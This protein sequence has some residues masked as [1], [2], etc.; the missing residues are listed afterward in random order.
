MRIGINL[1]AF[2]KNK[3]TGLIV[4]GKELLESLGKLKTN[5]EF[6]L[7]FPQSI[8]QDL[9]FPYE[10]FNYITLPL[11][12]HQK[13]KR[14]FFE[15][16]I[17]PFYLKKNKI[18]VLFNLTAFHPLFPLT[19]SVT[20]VH[21]GAPLKFKITSLT[22]LYIRFMYFSALKFSSS[23]ITLSHFAK[24]EILENI[25]IPTEKIKIIYPGPPKQ[26]LVNEEKQKAIL[27]K[28]KIKTPYFFFI[29]TISHNKN[30]KNLIY[31]FK[32]ISKKYPD[33]N[34]VLS[35][36]ISPE[37]S[38]IKEIIKNLNLEKKIIITNSIRTEEKTALFK[39]SIA[40][41]FPSFHEG[42]GFPVLEA[43][44]LGIPVLTSNTSALPEVA[45]EG[46]LFVNPFKIQS[47]A[48]S[49]K[50]ISFNEKLRK[51]LIKKGFENLK[52]FSWEKTAQ[53]T[54]KVLKEA[55]YENS[56]SS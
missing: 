7:F 9:I 46:A 49:L 34:L 56:S 41:V 6:F 3:K 5:D 40:L 1:L 2:Q 25:K 19:K 48:Q 18:N 36:E 12:P 39:N 27:K 21:S 52:R 32:I 43:Q 51:N 20:S 38:N 8:S 44:S 23:I 13:V 17:F 15:Q 35:G 45:G 30:I 16:F 11:N 22:K 28:F 53:E 4:Y 50:E 55:Y 37:L 29:G 31:A 33:L 10:N 42:F 26:I 54:L 47:I 24:K 14:A